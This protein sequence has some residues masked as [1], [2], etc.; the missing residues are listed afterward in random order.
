M[1]PQGTYHDKNPTYQKDEATNQVVSPHG[2]HSY[3]R[4]ATYNINRMTSGKT[5]C[6]NYEPFNAFCLL[7][8]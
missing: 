8:N 1:D 2:I 6:M 4:T 3:L 5:G 7:S